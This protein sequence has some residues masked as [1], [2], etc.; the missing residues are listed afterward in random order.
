[1]FGVILS[2]G[3][4]EEKINKYKNETLPAFEEMCKKSNGKFLMGTDDLT[5]LDIHCGPMWEI[6]YL[7][8][9]GVYANVDEILKIRENAPKWCAYMER[10]RN[11]PAIKP[12]RFNAKASENHGVRSRGWDPNLKCQLSCEILADCWPDEE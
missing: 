6:V 7:F 2:R 8:E 12:Y 3:Q 10:F 1:M 4:D 11:H 5:M 9:K